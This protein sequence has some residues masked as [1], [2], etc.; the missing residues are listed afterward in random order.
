MNIGS[1][2]GREAKEVITDLLREKRIPASIWSFK[3]RSL[4]IRVGS[5]V[6]VVP[7]PAGLTFY[8]LKATVEKVERILE[9]AERAKRHRSQIDL[10]QLIR[11]EA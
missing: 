9:D 11:G 6:A 1:I 10:E 7:V 5:S 4:H 3:G 8:G 2:R